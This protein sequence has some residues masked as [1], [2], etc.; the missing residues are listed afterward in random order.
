MTKDTVLLDVKQEEKELR[1]GKAELGIKGRRIS[2]S[3]YKEEG[4]WAARYAG[5]VG[6]QTG[7]TGLVRCYLLNLKA[8]VNIN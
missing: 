7:V 8:S 2:W 6:E 4:G 5:G 3:I 1:G